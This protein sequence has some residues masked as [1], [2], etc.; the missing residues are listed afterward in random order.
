MQRPTLKRKQPPPP[1]IIENKVDVNK[2]S[3]S[4]TFMEGISLGTGSALGHKAMDIIF[5]T[6]KTNTPK[7]NDVPSTFCNELKE[8]YELCLTNNMYSCKEF[9]ILLEKYCN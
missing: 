5:N 4:R 3:L 9:H 1:S 6:N 7:S 8:K 2:P